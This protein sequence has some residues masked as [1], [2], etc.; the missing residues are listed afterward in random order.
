MTKV[1]DPTQIVAN[2]MLAAG[3]HGEVTNPATKWID[4]IEAWCR[5]ARAA[6]S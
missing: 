5:T 3:L 6:R 2:E 1:Y 4:G